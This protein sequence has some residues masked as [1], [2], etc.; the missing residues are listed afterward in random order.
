M[1]INQSAVTNTILDINERY[2]VKETD[3]FAAVSS[4]SFDLSVYDIFGSL[5]A[6]AAMSLVRNM[7]ISAKL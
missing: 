7:K 3:V 2:F 4:F 5:N 6:G 1:L